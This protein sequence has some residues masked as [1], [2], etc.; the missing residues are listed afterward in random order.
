MK[1]KYLPILIVIILAITGLHVA[2]ETSISTT[3]AIEDARYLRDRLQQ[4]HPN[5]YFATNVEVAKRKFQSVLE[6]LR[7]RDSWSQRGLFRLLVPYV[8]DFKD[9]HTFLSIHAEFNDYSTDG[10]KIFPLLVSLDSGN[11]SITANLL[12][13]TPEA[14]AKITKINGIPA[15]H[16][17]SQMED[18]VGAARKPFIKRKISRNFP[19]YLWALF[20]FDGL[21]SI[22]YKTKDGR[23]E[24]LNTAGI[25]IDRYRERKDQV[26]GKRELNW[27]LS[28]PRKD[29]A[30]LTLNTF[31]GN[32]KKEFQKFVKNSFRRI[33]SQ[34]AK[35]LIIDLRNNGGGSTKLS[36]YLYRYVSG[37]PFCTFAE[38]RVKYSDPVLK[39][40]NIWNPITLF[41]VKVLGKKIITYK[42][43]LKPPPDTGYRFDGN[44]FLLTG[45]GTFSTAA[46][47]AA[48]IKDVE[49]G[50][51]VGE[52]TGGLASS[53]GDIFSGELP[54]SGLDFGVSYKHFTRTGGFDDG[55]GVIPDIRAEFD[56]GSA[57]PEAG[58]LS[59]LNN[60]QNDL[61]QDEPKE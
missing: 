23:E 24:K 48:T 5:L 54:N 60:Q 43:D 7:T 21:Y 27:E 17:V 11:I 20:K 14:G 44:L 25:T 37:K 46:D 2:G 59:W 6:E 51:I 31:R 40:K 53:Y 10:G 52:E 34:D 41:R 32:L 13:A 35:Y 39:K 16:I 56:Q 3:R 22:D 57:Q 28:F 38:V 29:V 58:E 55:R 49:A 15:G 42:N 45:P 1:N 50:T 9:G 8:A 19:I 12:G 26:L 61:Y 36:D 33:K 30:L 4:I 18:L 47:F